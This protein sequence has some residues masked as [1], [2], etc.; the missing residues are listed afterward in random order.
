MALGNQSVDHCAL[1]QLTLRIRKRIFIYYVYADANL[2]AGHQPAPA[3]SS[4]LA[5]IKPIECQF[6]RPNKTIELWLASVQWL[7]IHMYTHTHILY[8]SQSKLIAPVSSFC[9]CW[10]LV[11]SIDDDDDVIVGC[12]LLFTD[13]LIYYIQSAKR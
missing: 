5:A 4:Q 12:Q 11:L 10:F 1:Q 9:C 13:N 7:Y 2:S 3:R 6:S 8:I